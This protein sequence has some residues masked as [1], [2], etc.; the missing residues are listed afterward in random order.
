MAIKGYN[1]LLQL[2]CLIDEEEVEENQHHLSN[3]LAKK[4]AA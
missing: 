1:E 3:I 2:D 4:S